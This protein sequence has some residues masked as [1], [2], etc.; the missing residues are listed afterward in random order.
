MK[1]MKMAAITGLLVT[2][3][4]ALAACSSGNSSEK[5][6]EEAKTEGPVT[7]NYYGRPDDNGVETAIVTAFEEANPDIKVNYVEL[8]D[9]SNDRL[10]TINTVLQAGDSS[11]DVFAG[12][13]VWPPIFSSAGWVIPLD[14]YLEEGELD[15]YLPGPLS[16]FQLQG[17]TWG[18]PFMA[19]AGALYY[20]KDLLEKYNKPVPET[21][22]ELAAT[23]KEIAEAEGDMSGFVSYWKQNESLT[24]SMLEFYWEKGGEVVDENGKSVLD[25]AKLAETLTEM[26]AMIDDGTAATGIETFGTS[27]SRAVVTA[28]KSVFTRDWLSGYGPFNSEDSA[29]SG[30]MEIT[31]LPSYGCLGGWGVM[32]SA[33]SKHPEEAVEFAKFR[34]NYESQMIACDLVDIKPTL[35]AAYEDQ[36]LLKKKPELPMYLPVLEASK[37]RPLSPYYAEI[38]GVMQLEIHSV[39][40]GMTTPEEGAA[41]IV[42]KVAGILQ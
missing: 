2:A 32:V 3:S 37:P 42:Q 28:G 39:I 5:G 38:S 41:N 36:E 29:V 18:L 4:L 20:R 17:K 33:F 13:V 23:G 27:E 14:D 9:S 11:I 21:W 30:N 6:T 7:I 10:K 40:T 16:A 22:A 1:K 8:P 25:E 26:K 31:S 19:D 12:D 24:S 35:K 34:A 15:A